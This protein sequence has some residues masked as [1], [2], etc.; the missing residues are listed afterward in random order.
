MILKNCYEALPK[1]GKM[2]VVNLVI[3]ES[4]ETSPSAK[5][6]FQFDMF[7]MNTTTTEKERTEKEFESSA[8]QAGFYT[9]RVAC[10]AFNFSVVELFKSM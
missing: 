2:I 6:L 10:S 1:H 5:S 8:K 7:L 3:P 9:I 4:P